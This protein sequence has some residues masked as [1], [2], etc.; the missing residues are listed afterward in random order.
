M[1]TLGQEQP[2]VYSMDE[3]FN[4]TTMNMVL[5]AQQNYVNAMREDYMQGVK[6]MKDF[7]H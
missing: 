7:I 2:V 3:I 6:D 4:P 1:N 5:Q